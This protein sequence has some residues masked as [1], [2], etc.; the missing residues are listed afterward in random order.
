[1]VTDPFNKV[2]GTNNIYAL[3]YLYPI[4]DLDFPNGH[5]Q[6]AVAINKV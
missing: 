3:R 5:P 2:E 4:L 6:V 1:M